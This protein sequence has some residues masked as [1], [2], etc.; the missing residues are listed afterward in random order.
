VAALFAA[1]ALELPVGWT[2]AFTPPVTAT[3]ARQVRL[4]AAAA[5][6]SRAVPSSPAFD[7]DLSRIAGADVILL[8]LES[9]GA[10]TYDRR[11]IAAGVAAG[12]RA[13]DEA[14]RDT[15]R[16]VVSAFVESPTFGGSSW[17]AHISL[18]SGIEVRDPDVN[19]LLMRQTRETIV[20]L[21]ARHGY[22][23]AA[24][25]PG[26]WQRW[27]EGAFYGFDDIYGGERLGYR[28]PQFGWF[29]MTDQFALARLDDLELGRR[30]R[31][32]VFVFFP[33]IST[34]TPFTP[35]PPYQPAWA[36]MLTD[37]PYDEA[38]LRRS[39]ERQP[40]WL[41]LGPSYA[42]AVSYS[43]TTLAGYLRQHDG[44]DLVLIV[45]GDHQPPALVSG[46]AASW[47]V[48]VH[49]VSGRPA[50]ADR[51][52]SRGFRP[53]L[54]PSRPSLGRMHQLVPLLLDAFG[55][56]ECTGSC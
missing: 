18:M 16:S 52:T 35:V 21:F 24:L 45:I 54:E 42:E 29:D 4:L 38:D 11:A 23:T 30:A 5:R 53:G 46:P 1:E 7:S 34:H 20:T 25:M 48:P 49:V 55:D 44:D 15:H 22:R 12:R 51:L 43:L 27:P 39:Y 40:D 28:G 47:D 17:L 3:Y 10:V 41:D 13:L 6:G 50:V 33:T 32:P 37:R 36:R 9:Y 26:L 56:S 8:F 31:R 14:I 2:P 19:A